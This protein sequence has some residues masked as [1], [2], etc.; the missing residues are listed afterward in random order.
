MSIFKNVLLAFTAVFVAAIAYNLLP[1]GALDI[2]KKFELKN[3]E[4][5]KIVDGPRGF[6][7]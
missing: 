3:E 1:P 5:C 2:T 4:N 6:E 7:D